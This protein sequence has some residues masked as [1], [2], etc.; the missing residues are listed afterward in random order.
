MTRHFLSLLDITPNE[1]GDIFE[2]STKLK[3]DY[4]NGTREALYP[5][6]MM[7][8][9]FQK[10]SLR[11]RVSME[12]AMAHLG[13]STMYL[14][15]DVGWGSR[16]PISDFSRVLSSYVD[17]IAVRAN[18]HQDVVELAKYASCPVINCL[19]DLSHPCQAL[20]DLLTMQE[21]HG[22][23][24][25][26]KLTY[27]GDAN[28]VARSLAICCAM[29]N[30]PFAIAAPK[31]YQFEASFVAELKGKYPT[32]S[33]EQTDDAQAAV[34]GAGAVYTDV[35]AS[36]GQEAEHAERCEEFASYQVNTELMSYAEKDA[37]FLHCLPARRG[38]EVTNEV[39][40][41]PNCAIVQQAENRM[42]AQKGLMVW[43]LQ[44][45]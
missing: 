2:L 16:E 39:M 37:C 15:A 18:S 43:L 30:V 19:T 5:G 29:F 3:S 22:K 7:A 12:S 42:H 31:K 36:M 40:D 35:W 33:F 28:N 23:L 20:A 45:P 9:L 32:S 8:L 44:Q 24:G 4:K 21:V 27:V 25:D 13:G 11:T 1:L 38:E 14:G 6:R 26:R 17:L 34:R 10:Q 41:S